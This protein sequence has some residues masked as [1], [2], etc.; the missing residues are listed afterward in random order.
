MTNIPITVKKPDTTVP[1]GFVSINSNNT[2][3][4]TNTVLLNLSAND[5][6]GIIGY[7]VSTSNIVPLITDIRWINIVPIKNYIA[8]V[9]YTLS[10]GDGV[11]IIY[12]WYKDNVG[13]ISLAA[14]ASI[15][16]DTLIP[17]ISVVEKKESIITYGA[18]IAGNLDWSVVSV[19]LL[20]GNN[21]ITVDS[22]DTLNKTDSKAVI[23]IS[24]VPK[25]K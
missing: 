19:N 21:K 3:T 9:P 16:L 12:V 18:V 22:V 24:Y 15:I 6:I 4:K 25:N 17:I 13:N 11:K 5:N 23:N 2:F 10:S 8:N 20:L 14:S 1:I 7:Y